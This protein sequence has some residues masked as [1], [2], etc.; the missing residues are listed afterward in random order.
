MHVSSEFKKHAPSR[1]SFKE[2]DLLVQSC[3]V[4]T[5]SSLVAQ[6]GLLTAS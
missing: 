4:V 3:M 6:Q 1:N 5:R 2:I